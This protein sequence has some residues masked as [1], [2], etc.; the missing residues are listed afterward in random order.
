MELRAVLETELANVRD[1]H[2]AVETDLDAPP[3]VHVQADSLVRRLFSNLLENAVKH[4]ESDPK[5]V[6]VS[7]ATTPEGTTIEVRDN[8]PGI[9]EHNR[10]DLFG[11]S[12]RKDSNHGLGLTIATR[13]AERYD[14][15]I[16]LAETGPDG[17]VLA[18][19]LPR[20]E[21]EDGVESAGEISAD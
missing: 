18:V 20:I 9:P 17:T 8:G 19:T 5:R 11:I 3:A 16:E 2:G 10:G 4:N 12:I 7:V 6:S 14:G 1:R 13:L 15:A 21:V